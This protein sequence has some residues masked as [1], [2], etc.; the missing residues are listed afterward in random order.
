MDEPEASC[1]SGRSHKHF[2]PRRH[3][4]SATACGPGM[5]SNLLLPSLMVPPMATEISDL[6]GRLADGD[7]SALERLL[8]HYLPT[9]HAY[10]RGRLGGAL[11]PRESSMDVVQSV[12]RQI[13]SAEGRFRFGDED[14]FRAWLFTSAVNKLRE[15][16]RLHRSARRAAARERGPVDADV[17][18][19]F[20]ETP[21]Q[22]AVGAEAAAA[23]HA[24][25]AELRDD[26]RE[27]V[28]LARLVKL[29]HRVIAEV[30]GRSEGAVRQLLGR[31]M[32]ELGEALQRRGIDVERR[33]N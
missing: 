5:P 10:V 18:A 2:R 20:V 33:G 32:I 27:V 16:F 30:L 26:H 25:L 17:A 14:H 23:I 6:L 4:D 7:R 15:K 3:A 28:M 1:S 21:S 31:A 9:L 11:E 19:A 24:A 8:E 13:L 12:C 29:P 22:V